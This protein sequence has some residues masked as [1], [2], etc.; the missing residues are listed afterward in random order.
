MQVSPTF[1]SIAAPLIYRSITLEPDSPLPFGT[2]PDPPAELRRLTSDKMANL[3]YVDEVSYQDGEDW[4]DHYVQS[5][6]ATF[7]LT[8]S[9]LRIY[10]HYYHDDGGGFGSLRAR[11]ACAKYL[12]PAKIIYLD[13]VFSQHICHVLTKRPKV[14]TITTMFRTREADTEC[15]RRLYMGQIYALCHQPALASQ[16][17]FIF[18]KYSL[19]GGRFPSCYAMVWHHLRENM[20]WT[21]ANGGSNKFLIVNIESLVAANVP[22]AEREGKS[23]VEVAAAATEEAYSKYLEQQRSY[24]QVESWGKPRLGQYK[25]V[26]IQTYL[27]EYDCKGEFSDWEVKHYMRD[28]EREQMGSE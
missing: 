23:D 27:K 2:F 22:D 21:L 17:V 16:F 4:C 9:T 14:D 24:R 7:T 26:S 25:F 18:R 5:I 15:I 6:P 28:R 13:A 11:C 20:F 19:P 10:R 1:N 3:K 12:V 8:V